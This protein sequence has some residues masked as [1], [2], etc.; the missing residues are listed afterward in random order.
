LKCSSILIFV[1]VPSEIR[2]S[3]FHNACKKTTNRVSS[4]SN[5]SFC[6]LQ[7]S[8]HNIRLPKQCTVGDV[9]HELKGKVFLLPE[10]GFTHLFVNL[11]SLGF[12]PSLEV[13]LLKGV[14]LGSGLIY[15]LNYLVQMQS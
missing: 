11:T 9:I 3:S 2:G 13:V 14:L 1:S 8:V 15:R 10:W 12:Y 6:L 4:V 7:V 5:L